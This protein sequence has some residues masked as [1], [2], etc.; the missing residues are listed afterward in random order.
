MKKKRSK[1]LMALG[2]AGAG[3]ALTYL[4]FRNEAVE[5]KEIV[6]AKTKS[7]PYKRD[8]FLVSSDGLPLAITMTRDRSQKPK[9]LVQIVH[10]ILEHKNRYQ[11]F[12]DYLAEN[13]YIV[14]V[15]DNRG[16]GESVNAQFPLGHMPGVERMV[17]DQVNITDFIQEQYPD[18]P[19]YLY[20]HSFG[21]ILARNYLQQ[22]DHKIE[23][24]LLTGTVC[25]QNLAPLGINLAQFANRYVGEK[26]HS[27]LIK[28]LSGFGSEDFDWLT[29]DQEQLERVK[30]DP[31]MLAGYDNLGVY[32]IWQGAYQL[33]QIEK[34][35]CQKP[36]LPILSISG[37][38]DEKITG[39]Q[40][41]LTDTKRTLEKIGYCN[42]T[43]EEI[44]NMKHE[45][46][47]EIER[48]KVYQ[49]I[50]AFFEA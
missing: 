32:T 12:A 45:V 14:V 31:M 10:G 28:K 25:Y 42:V 37:S 16:H 17:E 4:L 23:K 21:S 6:Q 39:G 5:V 19:V 11:D 40:K 34:Y 35:T 3:L 18:L 38:E 49:E 20:G 15:S 13:G 44:M 8:L 33:K 27:W 24:L 47:N 36:S 22:H 41:G 1:T 26:S 2:L 9:A 46:L 50:L 43:M 30:N 7:S 29:Y 48:E